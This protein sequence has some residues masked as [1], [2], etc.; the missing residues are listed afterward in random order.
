MMICA[1]GAVMCCD[2]YEFVILNAKFIIFNAKFIIV[3][4]KFIIVNTKCI[5]FTTKCIIFDTDS[6]STYTDSIKSINLPLC[7]GLF[8]DIDCPEQVWRV[9]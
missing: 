7:L 4:T 2:M 8:D 3:N 5:N 1:T 9:S 6:G